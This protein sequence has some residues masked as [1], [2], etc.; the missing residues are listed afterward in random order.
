MSNELETYIIEFKLQNKE[1]IQLKYGGSNIKNNA[2]LF[3]DINKNI[4]NAKI[5]EIFR[6][7]Y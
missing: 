2:K 1:E 5:N 7:R 6:T 4:E 3:S